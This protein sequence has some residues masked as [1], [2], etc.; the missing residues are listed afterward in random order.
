MHSKHTRVFVLSVVALATACQPGLKDVDPSSGGTSGGTA[1]GAVAGAPPAGSG[2]GGASGSGV[3]MSGAGG[4]PALGGMGGS[5]G[6][7]P[8]ASGAG[9]G[10]GGVGIGGGSASGSGNE[11]GFAA[12]GMGAGGMGGALAAGAGGD[13]LSGAGS[14]VTAAGSGGMSGAAGAPGASCGDG[15]AELS[16][17]FTA[18]NAGQYFEIYLNGATDLSAAV[19][20][21][22][23]RKVAGK[24]GGLLIVVK[25]GSAQNYAYAQSAWNAINDMTSEF[26]TYTL[27]VAS[28]ASTDSMNTFTPAAVQIITMQLSAGA[29]W[30]L[31][32]AMTM[33]DPAALVNPTVIQIDE[34]SITGTGTLPGP[35]SFTTDASAIKPTITDD[36]LMASPPYAVT[37]STVTWIG[38]ASP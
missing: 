4:M 6:G 32:E 9:A 2:V 16:V 27:D 1:T 26:S 22:K 30:Y 24:A 8:G 36:G 11:A 29:P 10:A 13:T 37:G 14:P 28:P 23:A 15:C 17:P 18:W 33:E 35:W 5:S 31:D 38:P 19:I 25:D 3:I 7:V 21:V 12:G 34:I 20:T